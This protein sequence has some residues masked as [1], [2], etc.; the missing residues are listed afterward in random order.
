MSA[1]M[2]GCRLAPR[3]SATVPGGAR[4]CVWRFGSFLCCARASDV[5]ARPSQQLVQRRLA[6]RCRLA[7]LREGLCNAAGGGWHCGTRDSGYGG[8]G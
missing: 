1:V 2:D 3:A 5:G 6:L 7:P 8:G 4:D